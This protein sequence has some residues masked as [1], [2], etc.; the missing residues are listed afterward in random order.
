MPL[1]LIIG[2]PPGYCQDASRQ[3]TAVNLYQKQDYKGAAAIF[4]KL[5]TENP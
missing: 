4:E 3:T 5:G 1:S 2:V